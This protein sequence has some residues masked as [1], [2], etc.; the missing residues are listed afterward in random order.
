MIGI[1]VSSKM[2][3]F[4]WFREELVRKIENLRFWI[5]V[6]IGVEFWVFAINRSELEFKQFHRFGKRRYMYKSVLFVSLFYN[7]NHS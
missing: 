5:W 1:G 6:W 2:G 7:C 3:F 4:W